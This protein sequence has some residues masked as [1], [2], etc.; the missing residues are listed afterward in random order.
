MGLNVTDMENDKTAGGCCF[1]GH[2][3]IPED[4][5]SLLRTRLREAIAM[6][7]DEMGVTDFYA[8]GCTGF[9]TLAAQAV[10]EYRLEHPAVKLIVVVPHRDQPRGWSEDEQ[11]EYQRILAAASEVVCLA[12]HYY[13]GCMQ[14][15]NRYMVERSAVCISYQTKTE[16]GTASTV[17]SARA[18]GLTV[19]NLAEGSQEAGS[20]GAE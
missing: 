13:N 8:G 19:W 20:M 18:K 16:G 2:R 6:L 4:A 14:R 3:H 5:V 1:T 7:H 11:A 12:D 17:K 9:D 15:R 10:L